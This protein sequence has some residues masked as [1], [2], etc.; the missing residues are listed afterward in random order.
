MNEPAI[1]QPELTLKQ[2]K[3]L[4]EYFK[5]GNGRDAAL[6]SYHCTFESAAVIASQNLNKLNLKIKDLM[7]AK[8]LSMGDLVDDVNAM[9]KATKLVTSPTEMDK[10][11]PD[12]NARAKAVDIASKWLGMEANVAPASQTN[13]QINLTRGD[14]N[15]S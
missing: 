7:E 8:G 9:R 1:K 15:E 11:W 4:K 6:K 13:I 5:S 2:K 14:D 3:F 10:E 12:W